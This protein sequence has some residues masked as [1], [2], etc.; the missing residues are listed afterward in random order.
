M[1]ATDGLLFIDTTQYLNFYEVIKA[2]KLLDLLIEQQ[3]HVFVTSQI[4]AEVERNKL[5]IAEVFLE[6]H[7]KALLKDVEKFNVPDHLFDVST[8]TTEELHSLL[9]PIVPQVNQIRNLLKHAT[10]ETL[11]RISC[12][13]DEVTKALN[14][15]FRH[16]VRE[17]PDELERA[18]A[19]KERGTPPGKQKD[20]LGDQ[21]TWEQL[22]TQ[23]NA[24]KKKLVWII[25]S[26]E[27][28]YT[29]HDGNCFLNP[30]LRQELMTAGAE[31]F[32]FD[33][34]NEGIKD[35][36]SKMNV[37]TDKLPTGEE[38]K[39]IQDELDSLPSDSRIQPGTGAFVITGNPANLSVR[40]LRV[41]DTL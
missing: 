19:R 21:L 39:A 41:D 37:K 23:C 36:V 40:S 38:S 34:L 20:P 28:Y 32:C 3:E 15:I 13:E 1:T 8:K 27:D 17:T 31:A 11:D 35:F 9:G 18:R 33:N 14:K 26:D 4:A 24:K 25:S 5:R 29:K 2:K 12:S 16:A 30:V 7:F 22:L 10:L 6:E